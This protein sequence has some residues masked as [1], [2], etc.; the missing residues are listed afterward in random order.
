MALRADMLA[1]GARDRL[2]GDPERLARFEEL[3]AAARQIGPLTETHNYWIDRMVQSRLRRFAWRVGARLVEARVLGAVDDIL[4]LRRAE[5]PE[6]LRR[7]EDRR[8]V[9]AERRAE[10]EHRSGTRPPAKVGRPSDDED[11]DRF[12]GSTIKAGSAD[13]V[14]G[15][16]ASAG[17]VRGP[18]R[19]VI[20]QAAFR[21]VQP[22]DIIVC[23]SSNPSWVPLFAIA[24]GLVTDTGGVLSHAGV[25]AREFGLPAVVGTREGTVKIAD[26]Q[27][28]E[29]DGSSGVVR[30]L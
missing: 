21:N 4:F 5:V 11:G 19:V 6:L 30:L 13:E 10:H 16:G 15:T 26:G 20:D 2:A 25:V 22:G 23:F 9:V 27:M 28:V 12:E 18:A 24:G 3:L 17:I 7:P 14:R 29:V 1:R 8:T